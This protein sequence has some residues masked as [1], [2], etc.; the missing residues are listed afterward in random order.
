MF[1]RFWCLTLLSAVSA[2]IGLDDNFW[3]RRVVDLCLSTQQSFCAVVVDPTGTELCTGVNSKHVN[4]IFHGEIV[5]INN[6]ST[7][8]GGELKWSTLTLYTTAEPCPMCMSAM[9]WAG[10]MCVVWG[11]SLSTLQ[12]AMD[13]QFNIS[14]SAI[15]AAAPH[16]C[17]LHEGVLQNATDPLFQPPYCPY[18]HPH[19]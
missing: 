8:Y 5:A 9:I 6:C 13:N 19:S 11:T 12:R 7:T 10:L 1:T 3:M 15:V 14:A 17:A 18:C 16:G 4:P 2:R